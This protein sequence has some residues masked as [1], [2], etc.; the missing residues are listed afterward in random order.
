MS[1]D[2]QERY[3]RIQAKEEELKRREAGLREQQLDIEDDR[4]P[5]WP[6]CCP[7][8]YHDISGEIPI[9]NTAACKVAYILQCVWALTLIVNMLAAFGS[10]S[11]ANYSVAKYIV[12]SIIYTI[13]GIP[14]AFRV[15]YMKYYEQCK[16]EDL[17]L[18]WFLLEIIFFG[19]NVVGAVGLPNSGLCGVL[20][21]I[22]AFSK[23][24]G[25]I[26]IFGIISACAWILSSLGQGFL[27]SRSFLLYKNQGKD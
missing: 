20:Y 21:A 12:F 25:Y 4:K 8:V 26:K 7:F 27:G 23:G 22:D 11:M 9:K 10:G 6:V 15:N 16:K 18:S 2:A 5:N 3:A 13:L 24:N 17:S 19:L 14:L 1:M